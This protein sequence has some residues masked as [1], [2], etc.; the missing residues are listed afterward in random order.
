MNVRIFLIIVA[1][2]AIAIPASQASARTG[3][4]GSVEANASAVRSILL[5]NAA[6]N[7]LDTARYAVFALDGRRIGT[8]TQPGSRSVRIRSAR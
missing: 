6:L 7:R 4:A 3:K 2:I 8:S 1:A 5:R